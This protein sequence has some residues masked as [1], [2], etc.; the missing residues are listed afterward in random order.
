MALPI[1]GF[2]KICLIN[3]PPYTASVIF[4]GGCNFRCGF[5]HNPE[6]VLGFNE[7]ENVDEEEILS[8]IEQKKKWVD[9]C[10]I[11][12]GEPTL[13]DGLAE[14]ISKIK[15]KG[16]LVKLDTN[17]TNPA[18]LYELINAKLIDYIAMDVK[19]DFENYSK[20]TGVK[21]D[22]EKIKKSIDLIRK[23]GVEYEF[24]TTVIPGL[25]GKKEVFLI[26]KMLN[27]SKRYV[28]QNFR[29][30]GSIINEE[31]KKNKSYSTE[32]LEEMK[33][34]VKDYFDEVEVRE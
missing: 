8:Y 25:V 9:G 11:T 27:K 13:Y 12:G 32:E 3:Y 23:S 14:F 17:G 24:R 28:I 1:K 16:M 21:S 10:V 22:I 30:T 7:L 18:M 29:V 15:D 19:T 2:Q 6:L 20:I 4:L 34:L 26:G 33:N 5:C 31:L